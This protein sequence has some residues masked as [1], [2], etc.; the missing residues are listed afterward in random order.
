MMADAR[1]VCVGLLMRDERPF[2]GIQRT[3]FFFYLFFVLPAFS[4]RNGLGFSPL[5]EYCT[6]PELVIMKQERNSLTLH[7][8]HSIQ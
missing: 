7:T 4:S 8:P 6:V 5:F 1:C 3:R 2:H